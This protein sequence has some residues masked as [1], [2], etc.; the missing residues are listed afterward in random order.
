MC[1]LAVV[2]L[3]PI[4]TLPSISM[5]KGVASGLLSSSTRTIG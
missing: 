4:P 1:N 2:A 5:I 3:S